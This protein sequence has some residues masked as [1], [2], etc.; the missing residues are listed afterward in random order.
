MD[1]RLHLEI[2]VARTVLQKLRMICHG[3]SEEVSRWPSSSN[4]EQW[5]RGGSAETFSLRLS[6]LQSQLRSLYECL[7]ELTQRLEEEILQW[8]AAAETLD[9]SDLFNISSE[10]GVLPVAGLLHNLLQIENRLEASS[11]FL[12][13]NINSLSWNNLFEVEANLNKELDRI[14]QE[15]PHIKDQILE[16]ENQIKSLQE[17]I[18]NLEAQKTELEKHLHKLEQQRDSF[19]NKVSPEWPLRKGFDDG[20]LDAPWRT[21]SDV[22]EDEI[23]RLRYELDQISRKIEQSQRKEV[24]LRSKLEELRQRKILLENE[25]SQINKYLE[26]I[27]QRLDKGIP[28]DGPTRRDLI[29]SRKYGLA[30]CTNYVARKR[31]VTSFP[32]A[33][34]QPGHPGHAYQWDEQAV[35]AGYEVG[36]R[37]VKGSIMVFE[38]GVLGV[39]RYA[40]HVA[41]VEHVERIDNGFIITTS[42]AD[43]LKLNGR[44]VRGTHTTPYTRQYYM[45]RLPNGGYRVWRWHNGQKVGIPIEVRTPHKTLTFIYDRRK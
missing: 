36:I 27:Y 44:V 37:P 12:L 14:R 22:I 4:V 19:L 28:A 6:F 11:L 45:E 21:K 23:Q 1:E 39:N 41:Y 16:V 38:R 34:G 25:R 8:E 24:A 26:R 7:V 10:I 40:G 13:Y 33:S 18:Q 15:L 42:E 20:V 17:Y 5:W 31:D 29:E 32:N 35:R 2:P 3:L 43:T 9:H 30:G